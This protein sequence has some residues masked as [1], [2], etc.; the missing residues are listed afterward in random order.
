MWWAVCAGAPDVA[1][2][3][4]AGLDRPLL[5]AGGAAAC[6]AG[7]DKPLLCCIR[8]PAACSWWWGVLGGALAQGDTAEK[9]IWRD[10]DSA[11]ETVLQDDNNL[12]CMFYVC[13][14]YAIGFRLV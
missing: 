9:S 2:A 14:A 8:W 5:P 4:D 3:R 13:F 12:V 10:T 6:D 11:T 7:S 1:E